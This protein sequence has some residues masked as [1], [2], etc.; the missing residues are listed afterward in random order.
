MNSEL[1]SIRE[2]QEQDNEQIALIIRKVI[3]EFG[4]PKVGTAY[5][6][7]ALEN[8]YLHYKKSRS[9]Y[10]VLTQNDMVIGVAGI[11]PLENGPE[12]ICELQ[13]MYFLPETR[14]KGLGKR[15]IETCLNKAEQLGYKQCYIETMEN[16]KAAQNL[17]QKNG[18]KSLDKPLGDTGH[19]SCQV[20]F[21]KDIS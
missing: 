7:P 18:F 13:K 14:G 21:L 9:A 5:E 11:A 8:M 6:D 2:I 12:D 15:M 4:A 20:W 1:I 19:Y 16:M 17:Y 10:F 3:L